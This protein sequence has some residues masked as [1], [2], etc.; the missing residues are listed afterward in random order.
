LRSARRF[1]RQALRLLARTHLAQGDPEAAIPGLERCVALAEK[2]GSSYE[3]ARAPAVLAEAQA[4]CGSADNACEDTLAEAIRL[5]KKMG[6]HY[7]LDMA[8]EVRERLESLGPGG[9]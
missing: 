4:S 8:E 9:G 3:R 2:S 1:K 6:A 7:D 5:F